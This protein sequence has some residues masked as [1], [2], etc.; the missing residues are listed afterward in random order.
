MP[1]SLFSGIDDAACK[2]LAVPSFRHRSALRELTSRSEIKAGVVEA[3][4]AA[5]AHNFNSARSRGVVSTSRE[6]W[7]WCRP[8][9]QIAD[10]NSSPEVRLE[11]AI[12]ATCVR[13]GRRDWANQVPVASGIMGSHADR[14]RAIDLVHEV[15]DRHFELIELKIASDTPLYAAIE[16][17]GYGC[18]WLLAREERGV[19]ISPLLGADRIDLIVLAPRGYYAPYSLNR[20]QVRLD[21]ELSALGNRNGVRLGFRFQC[22]PQELAETNL[23]PDERLLALLDLRESV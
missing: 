1:V 10:H 6:N 18:A 22:L 17:I 19:D 20:L 14:R 11:R 5:I 9:P 15:A 21:A 12:A 13:G 3:V 7:R 16:I 23:P 8:Q 4:H 2:A